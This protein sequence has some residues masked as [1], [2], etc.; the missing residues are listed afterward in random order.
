[1]NKK[2]QFVKWAD[3]VFTCLVLLFV[4]VIMVYLSFAHSK[5]IENKVT[6]LQTNI[7]AEDDLITLLNQPVFFD[8]DNDGTAERATVADLLDYS[9]EKND[10][11]EF[12]KAIKE[13][14][15]PKYKTN[16]RS[17]TIKIYTPDG[18][19]IKDFTE[20][21]DREVQSSKS[22]ASLLF[23]IKDQNKPIRIVFFIDTI[24]Y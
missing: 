13:F 11:D 20:K 10:Y 6:E 14:L 15:T 3:V 8:F 23:P 22:K 1:M 9:Y 21:L 17:W 5:N 24:Y 2:A 4:T 19:L 18:K 16:A 7:G 12:E